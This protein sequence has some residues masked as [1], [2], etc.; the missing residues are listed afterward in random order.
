M[1]LIFTVNSKANLYSIFCLD[2]SQGVKSIKQLSR[3]HSFKYSLSTYFVPGTV[4]GTLREK[5]NDSLS[6]WNLQ[7]VGG[8]W[9]DDKQLT[10]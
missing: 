4:L 8:G 6:S 1:I 7:Y 3:H 2:D 5:N 10:Y 9:A